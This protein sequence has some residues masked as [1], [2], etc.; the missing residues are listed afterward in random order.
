MFGYIYIT[1]NKVNSKIYIGQHKSLNHDE[2]YLGSGTILKQAI[3]KYGEKNFSNKV[4]L[5]CDNKEE[6]DTAERY[7]IKHYKELGYQMYNIAEGGDGIDPKLAS[8]LAKERWSK[9]SK[10][11]RIKHMSNA[12]KAYLEKYP[13]GVI[14][15]MKNH[16][17]S[18]CGSPTNAHKKECSHY[19]V[20][21]ICS[22][23]GGKRGNHFATC[24]K[25][26][27]RI[28]TEAQRK[29]MSI[30]AQNRPPEHNERIS[31]TLKEKWKDPDFAERYTCSECGGRSNNHRKGCSKAPYCPECGSQ[32]HAHK[33]GCS[34]YKPPKIYT[35]EVCGRTIANKGNL[36]QHMAAHERRG[37]C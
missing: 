4:L 35:C 11:D 34:K 9:V 15:V 31:K 17:C 10:E 24:S 14:D 6:L 23:C 19:K 21:N 27:P 36:K 32:G 8:Q 22:E 13:R 18:E 5:E 29:N 26:I 1:T 16:I 12:R 33:K 20:T 30:A 7:F 2:N 25:Y 28:V 37:E 3:K